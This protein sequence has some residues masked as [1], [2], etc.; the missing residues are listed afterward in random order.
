MEQ[1]HF[2]SR[3]SRINQSLYLLGILGVITVVFSPAI[4]TAQNPANSISTIEVTSTQNFVLSGRT[5]LLQARAITDLG[6]VVPNFVP[7]WRSSDPLV[8]DVDA[9]GM[10]RGRLPGLANIEAS[11]SGIAGRLSIR[12]L[13]G[14]IEIRPEKVDLKLNQ[15][16]TLTARA[17]DADGNPLPAVR[18]VW[19]SGV[20]SI[21]SVGSQGVVTG[22]AA[23]STTITARLDIP[24]AGFN[25][26]AEAIVTVRSL[27]DYFA[28]RLVSND[29]QAR[30]VVLKNIGEISYA[31]T[32][33]I[34]FLGSLSNG[35][36][37][38]MV[39]DNGALRV[40][41]VSGEYQSAVGQVVPGFNQV[42]INARGDVLV[43]A[44]LYYFPY[45]ALLLFPNGQSAAPPIL[46][47][48]PS[49][50][51]GFST[52]ARA[53]GERGEVA[54]MAYNSQGQ[55]VL[56]LRENGR[57][58]KVATLRD[59]LPGIGVPYTLAAPVI[60]PTGKLVFPASGSSTW[61]FFQWDGKETRKI[62]AVG[63]SVLGRTVKW[64]S[65]PVESVSGDFYA[66]MGGDNFS[67]IVRL[68]GGAWNL[69]AESGQSFNPRKLNWIDNLYD[70]RGDAVL[71]LGWSDQGHFLF[72]LSRTGLQSL[73][74]YRSGDEKIYWQQIPQAFLTTQG[75]VVRGSEG[76][77][78]S[79]VVFVGGDGRTTS[80]LE[81]GANLN[82][83][84]ATSLNWASLIGGENSSNLIFRTPANLL[85][86][87]G[88]DSV[89]PV[90]SPGDVLPGGKALLQIE[91][92]ASNHNGDVVVVADNTQG[93]G[94][95]LL[96]NGQVS[97]VA[98]N[99]GTVKTSNQRTITWFGSP[100]AVNSRGQVAAWT[101]FE[102]GEGVFF[103][104]EGATVAQ[105]VMLLSDSAPGGGTYRGRPYQIAL[106]ESG[107]VAFAVNLSDGNRALFLWEK[108]QTRRILQA[109]DKG[110][111]GARLA[112][113]VSLRT[114][115]DK[116]Y[117]MLSYENGRQELAE[118]DGTRWRS[119]ISAGTKTS[120]GSTVNY[121]RNNFIGASQAG[122]LVYVAGLQDGPAVVVR[123]RD[124]R[125]ILVASTNDRSPEGDWFLDFLSATVS[126]QGSV[127]FTALTPAGA[128]DRISLFQAT[129]Y[130]SRRRRP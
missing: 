123:R 30:P 69:V 28:V 66:S 8:A 46:L 17:L 83:P 3:D 36:Q 119:I 79:K 90:L 61:G 89:Q 102:Q 126:E 84:A 85:V 32:D 80:W 68:T 110:P 11:S 6:S 47:P 51:G 103:Y 12:I 35:S 120:F 94:L 31:G 78:I 115:A 67:Q 38:V 21:A 97:I 10:V 18:F 59:P 33:R 95:Y 9:R 56:L 70:V 109:G 88:R 20:P 121:F 86:R 40:L 77:V 130:S 16:A 81:A 129:S 128:K 42:S 75:V 13:P 27:G 44:Y 116:F 14:R 107:R 73:L 15:Q 113:L 24:G 54:L 34:A 22:R 37:A 5:L 104:P 64:G 72:N 23:G 52:S 105:N 101:F 112:D 74:R 99:G 65:W 53:L 106:D 4:A 125:D 76:G 87:V 92:A 49:E 39:L 96:R 111:L 93:K 124:G 19:S 48:V 1:N 60:S 26:N 122:D 43:N 25:S 62:Y 117:V 82:F 127:F 41:A 100:V 98:E 55:N 114:A 45:Q 29:L 63:D 108:G 50:Y 2:F 71:F 58:E 91:D 7:Q 57:I 118:Y